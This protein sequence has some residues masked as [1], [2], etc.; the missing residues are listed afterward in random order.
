MT[1]LPSESVG[2]EEHLRIDVR[3]ATDRVVLELHG[4][5]DL[6]G[7]P[8]LQQQIEQAGADTRPILVLDLQDLQFVDSAGLRVVLAA[9]EST[10]R[11]GQELVLTKGSDQVQRLLAIVGVDAHLRVIDA[12]D[13]VLV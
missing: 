4:E 9:H 8:V 1:P 7:A 6:L 2:S 12:P 5:L 11:R 13:D 3:T 10:R